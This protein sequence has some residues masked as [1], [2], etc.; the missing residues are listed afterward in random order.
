M[1]NVMFTLNSFKTIT[2]SLNTNE[3]QIYISQ[4]LLRRL[5]NR[6]VYS[7]C[8]VRFIYFKSYVVSIIF[9]KLILLLKIL[10]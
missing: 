1:L 10:R 8:Y 4:W 5:N 3:C 9:P 7:I 6:T 2:N